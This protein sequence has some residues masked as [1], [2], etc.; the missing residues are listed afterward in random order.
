M[1]Q[2]TKLTLDK[3]PQP[4]FTTPDEQ[5][6]PAGTYHLDDDDNNPPCRAPSRPRGARTGTSRGFM[7]SGEVCKGSVSQSVSQSASQR[8][9][10]PQAVKRFDYSPASTWCR[11]AKEAVV[12]IG[13]HDLL[14]A[15]GR[16]DD[17]RADEGEAHRQDGGSEGDG[18][19]PEVQDRQLCLSLYF[20][21]SQ[22]FF[23]L[24]AVQ[25][26]KLDGNMDIK[27][28]PDQLL[29]ERIEDVCVCIGCVCH[30]H[31]QKARKDGR[32]PAAKIEQQQHTQMRNRRE[33]KDGQKRDR[34][35]G[36]ERER[37]LSLSPSETLLASL[38]PG[39][40]G[41]ETRNGSTGTE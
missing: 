18:L 37:R 9:Q 27:R 10:K 39:L 24:D 19:H 6:H 4:L 22:R 28:K 17:A 29:C 26:E 8:V 35:A 16:D 3:R 2:T 34:V 5:M 7:S 14:G 25:R 33:G 30:R 40:G 21:L 13:G 11:D 12:G 1:C 20:L 23:S 32:I 31:M 41:R 15:Y 38:G 36:E